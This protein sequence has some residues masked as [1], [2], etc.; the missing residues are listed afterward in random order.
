MGESEDRCPRHRYT[1]CLG[2][3]SG[4]DHVPRLSRQLREERQR[5]MVAGC[6]LPRPARQVGSAQ[7]A[8][9]EQH[10]GPAPSRYTLTAVMI[11]SGKISSGT[12]WRCAI[13]CSLV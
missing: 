10:L 4:W 6:G 11:P 2:L 12:A 3:Q 13:P 1:P 8:A 7:F 9:L 5:V